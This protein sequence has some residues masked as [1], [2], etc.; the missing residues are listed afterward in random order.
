MDWAGCVYFTGGVNLG[1]VQSGWNIVYISICAP[2]C[3]FAPLVA[4]KVVP[5]PVRLLPERR[6]PERVDICVLVVGVQVGAEY[7]L[8]FDTHPLESFCVPCCAQSGF[9]LVPVL[10]ERRYPE[11]GKRGKPPPRCVGNIYIFKELTIG[12]IPKCAYCSV[13]LK[14]EIG[15]PKR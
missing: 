13:P 9:P 10:P 1:Y 2:L 3:L 8:D 5:P 15:V 12:D 6:Y 7:R 11:S 14:D 4:A